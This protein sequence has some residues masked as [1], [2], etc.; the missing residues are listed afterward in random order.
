M[1][2]KIVVVKELV[3]P[4]VKDSKTGH[5]SRGDTNSWQQVLSMYVLVPLTKGHTS[6]KDRIDRKNCLSL[7]SRKDRIIWQMGYPY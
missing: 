1:D 3:D 5:L 2:G 7:F 4:L 6:N